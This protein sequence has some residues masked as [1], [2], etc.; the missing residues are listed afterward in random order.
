MVRRGSGLVAEKILNVL[1]SNP[2]QK[3]SIQEISKLSDVSWES[4]KRY[5]EFFEQ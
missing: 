5:L 1:S 4:T 3:M 2:S